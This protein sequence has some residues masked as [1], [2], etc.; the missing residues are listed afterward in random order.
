MTKRAEAEV[1]VVLGASK[2]M[3]DNRKTSNK[4]SEMF[5]CYTSTNM[6]TDEYKDVFYDKLPSLMVNM[7]MEI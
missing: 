5:Q 7:K 4:I 1:A 6:L 3:Y 2:W